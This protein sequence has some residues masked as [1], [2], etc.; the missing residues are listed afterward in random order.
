MSL[1]R[2]LGVGYERVGN[3]RLSIQSYEECKAI[4][5]APQDQD[6]LRAVCNNVGNS[7]ESIGV[8]E[9]RHCNEVVIFEIHAKH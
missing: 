8:S 9:L 1:Y 3:S 4:L 7:Y 5:T 2:G 6:E